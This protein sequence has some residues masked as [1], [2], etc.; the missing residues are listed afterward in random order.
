MASHDWV[1]IQAFNT[2]VWWIHLGPLSLR[3]A[4]GRFLTIKI[5]SLCHSHIFATIQINIHM[6]SG[7]ET[8]QMWHFILCHERYAILRCF[9]GCFGTPSIK[10]YCK[11][12]TGVYLKWISLDLL[13]ID[14][15]NG[16]HLHQKTLGFIN[17]SFKNIISNYYYYDEKF[18]FVLKM[19]N[20][21]Q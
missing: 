16:R 9:D 6:N 17:E 8:W 12:K 2:Y 3:R 19:K 15:G 18:Q 5:N 4:N 13:R 20:I 21:I 14:D 11:I 10:M 1:C 7:N